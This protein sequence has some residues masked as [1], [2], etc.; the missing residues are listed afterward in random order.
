MARDPLA[1]VGVAAL[2][3]LDALARTDAPIAV[4]AG[5][6]SI[7][8]PG[9]GEQAAYIRDP[10]RLKVILSTRRGGK[11]MAWAIEVLED[12]EEHPGANYLYIGLTLASARRAVWRDGF[13]L[14]DAWFSLGI[15]FNESKSEAT[16]P[17]GA[18]I[19]LL[20]MDSS[21]KQQEKARGGRYRK[22]L[23]DEAQSFGIDLAELI[24]GPLRAATTDDRGTITL[25]GTPGFLRT[26]LFFALTHDQDPGKAG[27]WTRDD[28]STAGRWSGHRWTASDNPH[29]REQVR[30]EIA[31]MIAINPRIVETPAFQRERLGR[32]TLDDSKLV[33]RYA[34]GRNDFDGKLPNLDQKRGRWHH[35]LGVDLGYSPDPTS[36]VVV[37]YH[38]HD[39]CLYVLEA[40]ERLELIVSA[41]ATAIAGY[42]KRF[43]FDTIVVDGANKQ[44][45]QELVQRFNLPLQ[46]ADK[47]GKSDFVEIMNSD[48]L[49]ERI[50]I[51]PSACRWDVTE[52][53]RGTPESLADQYAA[54]IWDERA[55]KTGRREEHPAC[56]N[57]TAD[58]V[59]YAWRHC[60]QYLA[61]VPVVPPKV[62]SPEWAAEEERKMEEHAQREAEQ[63]DGWG[64]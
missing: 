36:F 64:E 28:L 31:S 52:R 2:A 32:W 55:L 45:V 16:L 17:N 50:K 60:Y 35:V 19:F 61:R 54:L 47:R 48:W 43:S 46:P 59:L 8:D 14:L 51:D 11:S 5:P 18:M 44:A 30:E 27:Q 41:V 49:T 34:P 40:D 22:I 62:G 53:E 20:G 12:G 58:A 15:K 6:P 13:K 29:V 23:I 24:N 3:Q 7:I 38:D 42:Q 9:F 10:A 33:Y 37:A 25:A 21:A 56:R 57:D 1:Y 4:R 63:G 26:G 39:P